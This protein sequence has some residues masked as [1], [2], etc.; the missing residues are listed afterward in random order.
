M[1]HVGGSARAAIRALRRRACSQLDPDQKED[2]YASP[3]YR[4]AMSRASTQDPSSSVAK[5]PHELEYLLEAFSCDR[6]SDSES[7]DD[8]HSCASGTPRR[9]MTFSG[10]HEPDDFATF[11]E[12]RLAREVQ[13][14][15]KAYVGESLLRRFVSEPNSIND[16]PDLLCHVEYA[17]LESSSVSFADSD[18]P[19]RRAFLVDSFPDASEYLKPARLR[20]IMR[21][22]Q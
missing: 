11:V 4:V 18:S 9:S 21:A 6:G 17:N 5:E 19:V 16:D 22:M 14:R 10:M 1:A 2:E 12:R 20:E 8:E 7:S 15:K 3:S 13:F